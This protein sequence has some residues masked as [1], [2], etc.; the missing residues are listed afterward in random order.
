MEIILLILVIFLLVA[1]GAILV[2]NKPKAD[3]SQQLMLEVVENLRRE[4]SESS[5]KHRQEIQENLSKISDQLFKGLS[6]SSQVIQRQFMQSAGIIKEVTEKLTKLDETNKQVLDFSGKLQSLENILKNPKQRG[7]LG[8]YFLETMLGNVLAP[9]QYKMQYKF[10]NGEIVD[11]AIFY[12]DKIIPVDAKFSL[13]KYNKIMEET[14]E[15]ARTQLEK[16]FRLDLKNRID[17][18]SKYIRPLENTTDFAFMFIPAEGIYYNLL[19]YKVGTIEISSQ[20]L[21]EYAFKKHVI[22]VSPTSFFAYLE[23]VLHGLKALQMEENVKEI[24][25][26][27]G[28]LSKHLVN[29]ESHMQK[30]GGTLGTAVNQYNASYKEFGKID[31][32]IYKITAGEA[33]GEVQPELL[34]N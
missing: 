22:I 18:T 4:V 26:K 5:N 1:I 13:E 33:G 20:D 15:A 11:A 27:V 34:T 21:I 31:K 10:K 16:E 12:R 23:T 32:D 6:D 9:G 24:I 14:A 8:E 3:S 7:I 30:L 19:I 28:E 2:F 25:K 29:Y 17:E